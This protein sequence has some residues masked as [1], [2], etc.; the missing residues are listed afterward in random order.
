MDFLFEEQPWELKVNSLKSGDTLDGA[1]LLAMLLGQEEE[2]VERALEALEERRITLD[3]SALRWESGTGELALR[4]R[5][6]AELVEKGSLLT[7]LEEKDPLGIYLREVAGLPAAGDPQLLAMEYANGNEAAGERLVNVMLSQVIGQA[8]SL[9]G[10]GVLLLDLIQEGSLGL[11]QGI[12]HFTEGD[13]EEQSR[14]WIRQ[15]QAKA[16][17]QQAIAGGTGEKLRQALED[18]R[19]TDRKLLTKLGRNPLP[20]EIAAELNIPGEDGA[21]LEKLLREVRQQQRITAGQKQEEQQ[22]E[23]DQSPENTAYYQSRQ[24]IRDMLSGISEKDAELISLR[25]GLEGGVPLDPDQVGRKLGLTPEE[26]VQREAA[27]LQKLRQ[28]AE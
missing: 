25:Y 12:M 19:E 20:E 2:E 21:F 24:R 17:F 3:V 28:Q 8:M 11:W 15:Y 18:Y 23:E 26:V 6:E 9:T 5:R 4:L 1:A 7:A 27:V 13:F 10:K 16:I 14:W 22:E